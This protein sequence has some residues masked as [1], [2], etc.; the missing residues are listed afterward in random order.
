MFEGN[1][2]VKKK[3]KKKRGPQTSFFLSFLHSKTLIVWMHFQVA[4]RFPGIPLVLLYVGGTRAKKKK[5]DA[6][7]SKSIPNGG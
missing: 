4:H 5:T 6:S 3:K 7:F 2:E 1:H